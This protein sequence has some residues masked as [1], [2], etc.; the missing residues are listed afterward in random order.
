MASPQIFF[1]N[2][3]GMIF[4]LEELL[5]NFKMVIFIWHW[6]LSWAD[7]SSEKSIIFEKVGYYIMI[8][9]SLV[10]KVDESFL[11]N[12]EKYADADTGYFD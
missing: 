5:Q 2:S 1:R 11:V 7:F 8:C 12:F 4:N 6:G 9:K 10:L 3:N